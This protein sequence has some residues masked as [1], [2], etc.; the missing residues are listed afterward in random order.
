MK[1]VTYESYLSDPNVREEIE[2][3]VRDLRH[4]AIDQYIVTPVR[5]VLRHLVRVI[6]RHTAP[7]RSIPNC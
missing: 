3:E 2:Q 4:Q 6:R 1:N 7:V 5:D